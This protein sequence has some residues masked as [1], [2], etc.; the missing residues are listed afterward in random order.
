MTEALL[1]NAETK[2]LNIA[3]ERSG[4]KDG[5]PLILLHGWPDDIRTWDLVK[6][7]L[8]QAGFETFVPYL[9]GYGPTRFRADATMRSGQLAAL[10]QDLLEFADAVALPRFHLVGHDWGARAAYISAVLAPERVAALAGLSVGWGTNHPGQK[11]SYAQSKNY[12]YHWFMG[13]ERGAA[14]V[15]EDRRSFTRFLWETWSPGWTFSDAEFA[16]TAASFDNPDWAAITVHSYRHRWGLADGDPAYAAL[17]ARV[18]ADPTISRPTLTLHGAADGANSPETSEGKEA[19]FSSD[20]ERVLIDGAGHFP[21][22]ERPEETA[23][24]L[25]AFL[26]AHSA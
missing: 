20:Y 2:L 25:T 12:W 24:A 19:L 4:P 16:A 1:L 26:I 5:S 22:R 6:P 10:A 23:A 7:A 18:T 13:L 14:A 15:A 9:R 8:H 11:M 21:Q 17:E 3:Y